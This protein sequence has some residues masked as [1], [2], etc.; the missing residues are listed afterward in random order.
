MKKPVLIIA[1]LISLMSISNIYSQGIPQTINYQG[2]LKDAAGVVVP[3]GDYSLTFK[4]YDLPSGGSALWNETKT[5]NVVGGII[6]TQ[7]GS[8][9]PIT[10]A[11]IVGAAWLGITIGTGSELTP[12][13]TLSSVP[14]SFMS[15]TVPN[16]SITAIKIADAQVVKSLNGLKDNVNLVAGSNVTITPSGNNLTINATGGGSGIGGT[17]NTNYLPLFTN[18][19]TLGNSTLY[20][21]GSRIGLGTTT[22][23]FSLTVNSTPTLGLGLKVSR[24]GGGL[25]GLA[26]VEEGQPT[27]LRGW[28]FESWNQKLRINAAGDNGITTLKNLMTFDRNGNVG[29]GTENPTYPLHV[30][31]NR[32][33]AGYFT[34]EFAYKCYTRNSWRI[35]WYRYYDAVGVYGK[36]ISGITMVLVDIL[37]EVK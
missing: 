8:V 30:A 17:G 1:V 34:S 3:N 11:T 26:I 18:S 10:S 28:S 14:Y 19:T 33:Y 20:D 7:L 25:I 16:G 12:R 31:T 21:A 15:M 35:Y 9:T 23:D 5:I 6:N 37:M 29:I 13:I 2:V 22:P 32:K 24:T 4:L 27:T 36:C